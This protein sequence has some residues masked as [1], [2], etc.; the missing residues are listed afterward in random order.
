MSAPARSN[1]NL[2]EGF[3]RLL[4][5]ATEVRTELTAKYRAQGPHDPRH[6]VA[7][8]LTGLIFS[9][10]VEAVQET[11]EMTQPA[12]WESH[13]LQSVL[14][15]PN[16]ARHLLHRHETLVEA[17]LLFFSYSLFE[18]G[19]RRVARALEPTANDGGNANFRRVSGR[20]FTVLKPQWSFSLGDPSAFLSL[21]RSFRNTLQ[22]HGVF[23]PENGKDH[24]VA[25]RGET[26]A[27]V[28]GA[29]PPFMNWSF[30]LMLLEDLVTLTREIMLAP[31]VA[32]LPPI[33]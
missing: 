28:Y 24:V 26:Y 33:A 21:F 22:N 31:A 18:S 12:W 11:E 5:H 7:D 6:Y 8:Q 3:E 10:L 30:Q 13:G 14:A 1:G 27:F 2:T 32:A 29:V 23:V 17:S 20:L 15:Q 9:G 16:L 25:W 19:V 4:V